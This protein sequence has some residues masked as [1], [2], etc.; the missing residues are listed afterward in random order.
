MTTGTRMQN[1]QLTL[2]LNPWNGRRTSDSCLLHYSTRWFHIRFS[3]RY[4]NF[5]YDM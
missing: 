1:T 3:L 5:L 2:V 4:K